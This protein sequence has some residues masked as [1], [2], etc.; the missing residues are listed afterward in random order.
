[1][2]SCWQR[3]ERKLSSSRLQLMSGATGLQ[4][5]L[6][7]MQ[8]GVTTGVHATTRV[9]AGGGIAAA[10][11][12]AASATGELLPCTDLIYILT[13][14][15]RPSSLC[16]VGQVMHNLYKECAGHGAGLLA[17]Q[18]TRLLMTCHDKS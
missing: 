5:L 15:A 12:T 11:V 18:S 9:T 6:A 13:G 8:A 16:L 4:R 14:K 7:G 17:A 10:A 2:R 3:Q 1:M